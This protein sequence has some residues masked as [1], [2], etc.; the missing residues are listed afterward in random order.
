MV[1]SAS[2]KRVTT[3][4]SETRVVEQME[5]MTNLS[6]E[7]LSLLETKIVKRFGDKP[8]DRLLKKLLATIRLITLFRV[9]GEVLLRGSS[10]QLGRRVNK[11][12]GKKL[13][14][15]RREGESHG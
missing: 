10:E 13:R 2:R 9:A 1:N 14:V 15:I 6:G 4:L 7:E 12:L 11:A 5:L 8:S 3:V